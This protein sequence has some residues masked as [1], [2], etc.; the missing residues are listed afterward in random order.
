MGRV[1]IYT[2]VKSSEADEFAEKKMPLTELVR[3]ANGGRAVT[4]RTAHLTLEAIRSKLVDTDSLEEFEA[5]DENKG[6]FGWLG[7]RRKRTAE[8]PEQRT[9]SVRILA[10]ATVFAT[11]RR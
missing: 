8:V 3:A 1:V 7:R 11:S 6:I 10:V 5:A 9:D 2:P 4:S